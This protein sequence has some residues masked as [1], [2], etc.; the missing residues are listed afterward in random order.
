MSASTW[1][2]TNGS[3]IL[4]DNNGNTLSQGEGNFGRSVE[5]D[6]YVTSSIPSNLSS[7]TNKQDIKVYPNPFSN[8]TQI[9]INNLIGPFHIEIFDLN[10]KI[11]HTLKT[12]EKEFYLE[13]TKISKGIYWLKIKNQP[14]T[15]P[16]KII[17][18]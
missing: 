16:L 1:N 14:Q 5:V 13:N 12:N 11:I 6:F 2:G 7:N 17:I 4:N 18:Q 10:G 8:R 9:S 15:V 3:W